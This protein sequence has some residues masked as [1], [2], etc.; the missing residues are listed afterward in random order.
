MSYLDQVQ[1]DI[2]VSLLRFVMVVPYSNVLGV[3]MIFL[4]LTVAHSPEYS[5]AAFF[6]D[7][8][9][10]HIHPLILVFALALAGIGMLVAP[11]TKNGIRWQR[12]GA[13]VF[14]FY[15]MGTFGAYLIGD[16][17]PA[18]LPLYVALF[19]IVVASTVRRE[20][21]IAFKE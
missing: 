20:N 16:I 7:K 11:E 17:P 9:I 8:F 13:L 12:R 1:E 21:G 14:G 6:R 4:A 15:L 18:P 10:V 3:A 19:Y 2:R 5:T